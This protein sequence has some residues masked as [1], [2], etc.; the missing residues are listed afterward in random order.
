MV[1]RRGRRTD[2]VGVEG[3]TR[4]GERR[5]GLGRDKR[6]GESRRTKAG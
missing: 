2:G 3:E 1:G 6:R 4:G 5:E